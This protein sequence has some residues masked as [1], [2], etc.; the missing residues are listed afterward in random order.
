M[1]LHLSTNLKTDQNFYVTAHMVLNLAAR[2]REIFESSE[3]TEKR[4]VMN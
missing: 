4:Q 2:A 3:V 1:V